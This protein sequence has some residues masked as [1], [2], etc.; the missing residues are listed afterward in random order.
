MSTLHDFSAKTIRGD[1]CELSTFAGK[2]KSC[3]PIPPG[4]SHW[5]SA[6]AP[7]LNDSY[8]LDNVGGSSMRP[9]NVSLLDGM[10]GDSLEFDGSNDR[11]DVGRLL[12]D[13]KGDF[14]VGGWVLADDVSLGTQVI[15]D[16]SGD[17]PGETLGVEG[18]F[19]LRIIGTEG[20]LQLLRMRNDGSTSCRRWHTNVGAVTSGMW[21]HIFITYDAGL[22]L[23][24]I[25]VD[26]VAVSF[27]VT[28]SMWNITRD[29]AFTVGGHVDDTG[30]LD[31]R[32]DEVMIF[33]RTLTPEE[34]ANIHGSGR[35]GLCQTAA[36]TPDCREG[37][38]GDLVLSVDMVGEYGDA[39]QHIASTGDFGILRID[40]PGGTEVGKTPALF[41]NIFPFGSPPIPTL[42]DVPNFALDHTVLMTVFSGSTF[43]PFG[44][45]TL[46][47]ANGIELGFDVPP[48]FEGL[49]G[50]FQAVTFSPFTFSQT[51]DVQI[52]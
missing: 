39:P 9:F 5:W 28:N 37:S 8:V 32:I 48:G 38:A 52:R 47:P 14:S 19:A 40:S 36:F 51:V 29:A 43:G 42:P 50:R 33:H 41:M 4:I 1:D 20:G 34:V 15:F 26:G 10:V 30:D 11:A 45:P 6:D 16:E 25:Y 49:T 2:C 7:C 18:H 23:G 17:V 22:D 35:W 24:L 3:T 46:L 21:H 12:V 44:G 27:P 31:G 13:T